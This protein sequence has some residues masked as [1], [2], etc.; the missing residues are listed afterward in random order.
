[1]LR[2]AFELG[3]VGWWSPRF[4]FT[5]LIGGGL[6]NQF[7]EANMAQAIRSALTEPVFRLMPLASRHR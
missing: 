5:A 2:A 6:G 1:M 7:G 3:L 4:P